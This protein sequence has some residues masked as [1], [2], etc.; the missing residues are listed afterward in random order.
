MRRAALLLLLPAFLALSC[1]AGRRQA[2]SF[3]SPDGVQGH[4]APILVAKNPPDPDKEIT[5]RRLEVT[6]S[7]SVHLIHVRTRES[8]H[9]HAEH[10]FTVE[11]LMGSGVLHCL[12]A[13]AGAGGATQYMMSSIPMREGDAALIKRGTVHWFV[14]GGKEPASAL[15]VFSPP[16]NS[17]DSIPFP[18]MEPAAERIMRELG[19]ETK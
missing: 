1:S 14:N 10:D 11:L 3:L 16:Y 7:M 4:L 17:R 15:V 2:V 12:R 19:R 6:P 5:A 8:P 9:M 13:A 18:V